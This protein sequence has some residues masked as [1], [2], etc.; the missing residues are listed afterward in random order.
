MK[1]FLAIAIIA[2][3]F[4]LASCGSTTAPTTYTIGGTVSGLAGTGLV[5]QDNGGDNLP[6][7]QNGA[8]TFATALVSG[9]AYAA[10]VLTQPTNPAQTCAVTYGGTGTVASNVVI[11]QVTCNTN[12]FT[13]GVNVSGLSG[14]GLVLQNNG[15]NNLP[16]SANGSF[17][18]STVINRGS[19]YN[20]TVLTQPSTPT[21]NCA[22]TNGYGANI[23]GNV[24]DIQVACFTTS[25]TYTIGGTVSGLAGTGLV[26][27]DNSG[28]NLA[29]SKN[30]SFTFPTAI[31]SG[32]SFSVTAYAQ[33]SGPTQSCAVTGGGGTA[34][35]N[36][37]GILV[38]CTTT[39]FMIGGTI[40]GLT[41]SGLILQ[42]NGGNSLPVSA[43][44]S[45][46]TF[47]SQ[48]ASGQSYAVTVL[49]QP[50]PSCAITNGSGAVG[51]SSISNIT[52]ACAGTSS[53]IGATVSGLL[54][55]TV[56]VLQDNGGDTLTIS[57]NG[58][59]TNFNTPVASGAAYA[60]T[61][62]TQPAGQTCTLGANASGNAASANINV[63]VTCGTTIAV[64]VAHSCALTSAGTVLCWGSN[65][66]GQL[67]NGGTTNVTSPVQVVGLTSSAVSIAAGS[68]ST[69]ALTSLGTVWCWGD[70][71]SGQLGNGTFTQSTIPVQ[72]MDPAGNAPLSDIARIAAGQSHTCAVTAAGAALCWGD[73]SQGELGNGTEIVSSLPVPVSGLAT[74]VS[75]IAAGSD[76]TCA[77]ISEGGA[78]CWGDGVSGQLGNG[79]SASST[80]PSTVLDVTGSSPLSGVV[81][82]SAGFENACAL[83]AEGN[84][85][86][87]G[88]DS[89]GQLGNGTISSVAA[90]PVEVL[91]SNGN[92]PLADVIAISSGLDNN[93]AVTIT[94]MTECW[95]ANA[96]GQLGNGSSAN[97]SNPVAVAG[98]SS[99]VAAIASGDLHTC[100]ATSAGTIQCWGSNASGQ[101]ANGTTHSSAIPVEALGV[102]NI[103]LLRLF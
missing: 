34:I 71:S 12:S 48:V 77:V 37:T 51:N 86:C 50:S 49:A 6:I 82:I 18:F 32:S 47:S 59:A 22:V 40:S 4:F 89:A 8:F 96:S 17:M 43:N 42:D 62:L 85:F 31:P 75:T 68:E 79:T 16:V 74:G 66:F 41:G 29:V 65:E 56:V 28:D 81:T 57:A 101:L 44:A 69:C 13:V 73:N 58:I 92:S 7:I 54:A 19:N 99:V 60:V 84:V 30:G 102:N 9:N 88:A 55:N 10:T 97:S 38:N 87:W 33:P 5:L 26:L 15:G 25:V 35:A 90:T 3:P 103:G 67:G 1:S 11:V 70:N 53:N 46:F 61:V 20:V 98:L 21:Q 27:Q 72:V 80:T 36:I 76:F 24:T 39:T 100:A 83:T 95:G 94:G 2:F 78:K 93:C 63:A 45:S 91:N 14:T 64:G 52:I 23:T